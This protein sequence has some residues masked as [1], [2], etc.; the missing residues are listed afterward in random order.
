MQVLAIYTNQQSI[1][2]CACLKITSAAKENYSYYTK[3][4]KQH[5]SRAYMHM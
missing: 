1:Q 5:H 4:I 2:A 3:D